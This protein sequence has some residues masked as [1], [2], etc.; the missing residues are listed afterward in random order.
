MLPYGFAILTND[1][2]LETPH[3][4]RKRALSG[5]VEDSRVVHVTAGEPMRSLERLVSMTGPATASPTVRAPSALCHG[6][7]GTPGFKYIL[8]HT[9]QRNALRTL[10]RAVPSGRRLRATPPGE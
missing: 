6:S 8:K 5:N 4:E 3:A 9:K 7:K 2:K 1:P 10:P